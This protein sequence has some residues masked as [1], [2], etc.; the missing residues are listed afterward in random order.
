M[1]SVIARN[2]LREEFT[3]ANKDA[4]GAGGA[5]P[6]RSKDPDDSLT[7]HR[8]HQGR[9]VPAVPRAALRPRDVR[10]VPAR[11]LRPLRVPE[12]PDRDS[13]STTPRPTCCDKYPGKVTPGR[14]RRV[15]VRAG[16]PGDRAAD[17]VARASSVDRCRAQG[18][19][20]HRHAAAAGADTAQWT[21]QEWVHFLEGMPETLTLEQLA[22]LDAAYHFTGTPTA[23]S[24]SAGIRW[25]CAAATTPADDAM[26]AFLQRDRP[27]QADH[28]D[29]R[30]AGEDAGRPGVRR[31][32][33]R[34]GAAGLPPDHHRFG[35]SA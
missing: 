10:C 9:V 34:Q 12:H 6:A 21:T 4:A 35:R 28:A 1:E 23:R 30:G 17:C 11:L 7:A 29:L 19:A 18:L 27:A 14:V 31:G 24:R 32:R 8:L 16:H 25:R 15:A 13:S 33:V 2:E 5:S 26:A 20:R 3:D 22:A